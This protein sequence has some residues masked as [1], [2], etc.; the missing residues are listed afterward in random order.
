M[1]I[2]NKANLKKTIYYLKRNGLRKTVSTLRER[3]E[4]CSQAPYQWEPVPEEEKAVQRQR[5]AEGFSNICFSIVVPTYHTPEKYLQEMISSVIKQTYPRW[6]L[7]LAD[8]TEDRETENKE[9]VDE[10]ADDRRKSTVIDIG[11]G[12]VRRFPHP[13]SPP[14]L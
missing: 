2:L 14:S 10:K 9:S 1:G 8:A 13:L 11:S 4:R 7:I 5:A 3:L 12:V 6:E